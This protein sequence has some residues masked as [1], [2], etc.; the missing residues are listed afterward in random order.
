VPA[1]EARAAVIASR[2]LISKACEAARFPDPDAAAALVDQLLQRA[3]QQLNA[4]L[5]HTHS[6]KRRRRA[7]GPAVRAAESFAVALPELR[8]GSVGDLL[9]LPLPLTERGVPR[10]LADDAAQPMRAV[11]PPLLRAFSEGLPRLD[12]DIVP[13]GPGRPETSDALRFGAEGLLVIWCA[14]HPDAPTLSEN[15]GGFVAF[16]EDTL[17]LVIKANRARDRFGATTAA[18]LA[19]EVLEAESAP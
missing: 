9:D 11:L 13:R 2:S 17:C 18:R 5:R 4:E 6:Q 10:A 7:F 1:A 12:A 19:R 15:T 3:S 16:V 8:C 14:Q